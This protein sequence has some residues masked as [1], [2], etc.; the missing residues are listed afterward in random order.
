[1]AKR[2]KLLIVDDH[3]E[4]RTLIKMTLEHSDYQLFETD[5]GEGAL[6]LVAE[7]QPDVII[8]DIMMP[9]KIDG[10]EVCRQI[11]SNPATAATKVILLSAKGQ[12]KDIQAGDDAGADAYFIKPFS[13][14]SLL[15]AIQFTQNCR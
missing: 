15:E 9:G 4:L 13:P 10:I 3:A 11:K 12:K 5:S 8:L 1:M 6:Q 14:T 2:Q 7:T